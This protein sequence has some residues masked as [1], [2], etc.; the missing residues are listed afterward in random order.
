MA[1]TVF[2]LKKS[3]KNWFSPFSSVFP[4]KQ[5]KEQILF[6]VQPLKMLNTK[7]ILLLYRVTI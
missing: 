3:K 5:A 6:H 2:D 1:K 7:F 4:F